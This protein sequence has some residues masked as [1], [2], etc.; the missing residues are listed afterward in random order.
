M[1]V[2]KN[3]H[4]E[5]YPVVLLSI[6]EQYPS[7]QFLWLPTGPSKVEYRIQSFLAEDSHLRRWLQINR[8]KLDRPLKNLHLGGDFRL[9]AVSDDTDTFVPTLEESRLHLRRVKIAFMEEEYGVRLSE[10]YVSD[11]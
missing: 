9:A 4:I 6:S 11:Q 8:N 3:L 7:K 1:P 2:A 5:W 10:R